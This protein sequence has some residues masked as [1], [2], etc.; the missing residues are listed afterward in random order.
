MTQK[1]LPTNK[2]T[3]N[4]KQTCKSKIKLFFSNSRFSKE[5]IKNTV[6]ILLISISLIMIIAK[7]EIYINS[8]KNGLII[9]TASVLPALFPF[10]FFSTVLTKIG[11]PIELAKIFDKPFRRM[12]NTSGISSYVFVMSI[13]CGYPVGAKL[14]SELYTAGLTD[15]KQAEKMSAFCST[16]GPLFILGTLGVTILEDKKLSVIILLCHYLSAFLNGFIYRGKRNVDDKKTLSLPL[17]TDNVL[18]SSISNSTLSML[19]LCGYIVIFNLIIDLIIN[20]GILSF[21]P[22]NL[23]GSTFKAILCGMI[24]MTRGCIML[25]KIAIPNYLKCGLMCFTVSFAGTGILFQSMGFLG[26]CGIKTK[27]ILLQKFTQS[28]I[29]LILGIITSLILNGIT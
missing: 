9:F 29:A 22:C 19:N 2:K 4:E 16:S 15:K 3:V 14:I 7:P 13:I 6:L 27:K 5:K 12:Y 8:T 11:A 17:D 23:F 25:N 21:L 24:E 20:S 26:K 1:A 28:I 10:F 18:A